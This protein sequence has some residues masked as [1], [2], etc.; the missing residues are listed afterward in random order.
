MSCAT[1]TLPALCV[2]VRDGVVTLR[3]HVASRSHRARAEK[4]ARQTR[5][6]R[7]LH[8]ELVADDDLEIR[9]AQALSR[10]PRTR[11]Y[12]IQV[13]A[14][15]GVVHLVGTL[16][17]TTP[18]SR[19][20][21]RGRGGRGARGGSALRR[22][23]VARDRRCRRELPH[24]APGR[25]SRLRHRRRA[26]TSGSSGDEPALPAGHPPRRGRPLSLLPVQATRRWVRSSRRGACWFRLTTVAHATADAI[27]LRVDRAS[28]EPT[29][30]IPR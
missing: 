1:W 2:D 14:S 5:G 23:R 11:A 9:V 13:H 28:G 6:V 20:S 8:D 30:G 21:G 7:E 29:P 10:D 4:V 24:P 15:Q 27:H 19:D 17:G 12:Y 18:S 25:P 3:G 22:R 16:Q 26:G